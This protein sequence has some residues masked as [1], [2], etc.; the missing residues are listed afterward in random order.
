[1]QKLYKYSS[2]RTVIY[3]RPHVGFSLCFCAVVRPRKSP[4]VWEKRE[5]LS[6]WGELWSHGTVDVKL[7]LLPPNPGTRSLLPGSGANKQAAQWHQH[8]LLPLNRNDPHEDLSPFSVTS[9]A[10]SM[11]KTNTSVNSLHPR[12]QR[13]HWWCAFNACAEFWNIFVVP[14]LSEE[15]SVSV[16]IHAQAEAMSCIF[17]LRCFSLW[18]LSSFGALI[19][20]FRLGPACL[21]EPVPSNSLQLFL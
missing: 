7:L 4:L 20:N 3:S 14:G 18:F 17:I 10:K 12:A 15:N 11:V 13:R 5:E 16:F 1:M 21:M 8:W 6:F 19:G 9:G 2:S